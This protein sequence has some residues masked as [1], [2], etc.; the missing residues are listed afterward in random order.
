[1]TY[2]VLEQL[3]LGAKDI[4]TTHLKSTLT[5]VNVKELATQLNVGNQ[6]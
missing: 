4:G 3:G 1:M 6:H 2:E 5:N